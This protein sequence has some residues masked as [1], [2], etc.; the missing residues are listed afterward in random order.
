MMDM[1]EKTEQEKQMPRLS[2]KDI[3]NVYLRW[4]M[5]CELTLNFERYQALGFCNAFA[6][7]LKKLY[8]PG[9]ELKE[10]LKRHLEFFNTQAMIGAVIPGSV[11]AMEEAKANGNDIP[12]ETISS[13]KTGLM[14]PMAGIGDALEGGCFMAIINAMGASFAMQGNIFGALL[15]IAYNIFDF[16]IGRFM[17]NM[18]YKLGKNSIAKVLKGRPGKKLDSGRFYFRNVYDGCIIGFICNSFDSIESGCIWKSYQFTGSFRS[19][20]TW[21]SSAGACVWCLLFDESKENVYAE[22]PAYFNWGLSGWG[23][24]WILLTNKDGGK[25]HDT[26]YV[27]FSFRIAKS[28]T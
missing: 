8:G 23:I 22:N 6:P 15:I 7:C 4:W 20:C 5:G 1:M 16:F 25:N 11:L 13:F 21:N 17:F 2:K 3:R 27:F 26:D 18:G 9:D 12:A 24:N 19:D 10:A 14:G 28:G